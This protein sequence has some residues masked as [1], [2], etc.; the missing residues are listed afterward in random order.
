MRTLAVFVT[1]LSVAAVSQADVLF[2]TNFA[3]A[4][5]I[6]GL[7]GSGAGQFNGWQ[8]IDAGAT[9]VGISPTMH[10]LDTA[11]DKLSLIS[12]GP[13]GRSGAGIARQY[14]DGV[15]NTKYEVVRFNLDL[16][17]AYPAGAVED[18]AAG[19]CFGVNYGTAYNNSTSFLRFN[20]DYGATGVVFENGTETLSELAY[21]RYDLDFMCNGSAAS[22]TYDNGTGGTSSI[23]PGK[24]D[25]W[26][27]ATKLGTFTADS[28]TGG[29]YGFSLRT[30]EYVYGE[31]LNLDIYKAA[32]YNSLDVPEPATVALLGLSGI[33]TV[34]RSKR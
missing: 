27:G 29:M 7:N 5:D 32:A 14:F 34:L 4:S 22:I 10:V 16:G 20:L 23:A 19:I 2:E 31:P 15:N 11:N 9:S 6:N 17:F 25:I 26:A 28:A 3:A 30:D 8:Y 21:G 24:I 33:A 18:N 1:V 13:T 12:N